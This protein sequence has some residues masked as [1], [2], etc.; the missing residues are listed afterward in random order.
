MSTSTT[1]IG[2][3]PQYSKF[4][5]ASPGKPQSDDKIPSKLKM[6]DPDSKESVIEFIRM[7]VQNYNHASKKLKKDKDIIHLVCELDPAMYGIMTDKAK[8]IA[9]KYLSE[10]PKLREWGLI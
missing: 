6:L 8:K 5:D 9:E 4:S 3:K 7:D 1:N 10:N 2:N